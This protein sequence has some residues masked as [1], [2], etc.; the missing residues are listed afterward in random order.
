MHGEADPDL[1]LIGLIPKPR[2]LERTDA[3]E[4]DYEFKERN[5]NDIPTVAEKLI[6]N[7]LNFFKIMCG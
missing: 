1:R 7:K 2:D 5:F 4:E 6:K 3:D